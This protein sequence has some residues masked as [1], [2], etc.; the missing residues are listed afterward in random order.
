VGG[1][2]LLYAVTSIFSL[3]C[4]LASPVAAQ[5]EPCTGD[6][7]GDGA[8]TVNELIVGVNIAL[9]NQGVDACPAFDADSSGGVSINELIAAV[10]NA[11]NG[12]GVVPPTNTPV[13]DTPTPTETPEPGG[14]PLGE[15]AFSIN[16]TT[17]AAGQTALLSNVLANLGVP[18]PN[19]AM[20]FNAPTL[21]LVA[22]APGPDGRAPLQLAED[23]YIGVQALDTSIVCFHI[24]ADG[25]TGWVDCDGGP[26]PDVVLTQGTGADAAPPVV[27]VEDGADTGPGAVL[28]QVIQES[29]FLPNGSSLDDCPL[30][31]Y[32]PPT[33]TAYTTGEATGNKGAVSFSWP[34]E[35]NAGENFSCD[36]WTTENG[37]GILLG[38][39]VGFDP[40][41]GGDS[42][43]VLQLVD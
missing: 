23:V 39:L 17:G 20:A 27:T 24:I 28:L 36:E 15:R 40:R 38:P 7:D 1:G 11:L 25:S 6:C 3:L 16:P 13:P 35:G 19:G 2:S 10:S 42:A 12:C 34:S 30:A 37:P 32:D 21:R 43:N 18:F 31:T 14:T 33:E 4:L 26:A 22:G 9:E 41:A 29:G 8:V 5:Q